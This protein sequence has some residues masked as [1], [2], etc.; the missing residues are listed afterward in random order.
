MILGAPTTQSDNAIIAFASDSNKRTQGT[1]TTTTQLTKKQKKVLATAKVKEINLE[2]IIEANKTLC[3]Y[4]VNDAILTT[5]AEVKPFIKSPEIEFRIGMYVEVP[6]DTSSGK[7]RPSGYGYITQV[8]TEDTINVVDVKFTAA[9]DGGRLHKKIESSKLLVANLHQGMM[10]KPQ[11]R[12]RE[13][14]DDNTEIEIQ[15]DQR[16]TIEILLEILHEN[17]RRRPGWHR[18]DLRMK[19]KLENKDA[20]HPQLNNMEKTQLYVESQMIR[21]YHLSSGGNK[22]DKKGR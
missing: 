6:S 12:N 13:Y 15:I 18:S 7:N 19:T 8:Y 20:R 22:H 1:S 5:P 9:H 17:A 14:V 10:I 3:S 21:N 2:K 4:S 16:S 11:G